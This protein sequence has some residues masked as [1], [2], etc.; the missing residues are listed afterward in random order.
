MTV[1]YH[2]GERIQGT[3]ADF[4]GTPAV[5]GGWKEVGRHTFGSALETLDV[6]SLPDKRY[7]MV[8]ANYLDSGST[9]PASIWRFN[10]D[11]GSNYAYRRN[12]DGGS[13]N[14]QTS[15]SY[16]STA[17]NNIA[18]TGFEVNYISNLSS[19][20][21]LLQ[22]NQV[23]QNTAGAAPN[24]VENACKWANTSNALDQIQI[25]T[26]TSGRTYGTG[27]EMVVLGWDPDDTHTDNFWEEL[28]SGTGSG[29]SI[30]TG[31]FTAKKYLWV[32]IYSAGTA[33]STTIGTQF[34]SDTG[35]NYAERR[36]SNG[37][38]DASGSGG[39]VFSVDGNNGTVPMFYNL[40][41]INNASNEKL[42]IGNSVNQNTAGE[43]TAPN[44]S[45]T[46]AKWT[47]TSAQ[48]TSIQWKPNS[49]TTLN[50]GFLYKVWGSN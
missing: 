10:A 40:L 23:Y 18:T 14:P 16:M 44:R 7:Y 21:K 50:S 37:G 25:N 45:E 26:A 11:T 29:S 15:K 28:A 24:R 12:A 1:T 31:T 4:D 20:E 32:Q 6:S 2:S 30:N 13:D 3:Q 36:S 43:G 27:S 19:K 41:I 39:S 46:V 47:N 49:S 42:C 17:Y 5:S 48:I 9:A 8:L 38:A 34:N 22:G 33:S 35:T